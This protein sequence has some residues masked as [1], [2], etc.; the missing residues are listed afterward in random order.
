MSEKLSSGTINPKQT[1]KI[2]LLLNAHL[3]LLWR[4]LLKKY[5]CINFYSYSF[6]QK[7]KIHGGC[8]LAREEEHIIILA[9]EDVEDAADEPYNLCSP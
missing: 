8:I 3:A 6:N 9:S 5:C 7:I 1:N 2:S 4:E